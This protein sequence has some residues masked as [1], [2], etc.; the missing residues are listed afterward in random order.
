MAQSLSRNTGIWCRA[1]TQQ[2]SNWR[3]LISKSI[4]GLIMTAIYTLMICTASI[5]GTITVNTATTLGESSQQND[6]EQI[7][8]Y[9]RNAGRSDAT[10]GI[11]DT[12]VSYVQQ[13]SLNGIQGYNVDSTNSGNTVNSSGVFIPGQLLTN[14]LQDARHYGYIPY[15][16]VGGDR[17]S[18]L[19]PNPWTWSTTTWNQYR[20]YVYKFVH[21]VAI[22]F[23]FRGS[24]GFP[25]SVFNITSEPDINPVVW[26][27][28]N[29]GKN[30][31]IE[32]YNHLK[33]IYEIWQAAV[34]QVARENPSRQILV[35]GPNITSF[36]MTV[37]ATYAPFNWRDAFID[38]VANN[39]WRL[40]AFAYHSYGD[41]EAVGNS[42]P[43]P[44][45]GYLK[46]RIQAIRDKLN[47]R[48]LHSKIVQTEWGASSLADNSSLGRINYSH[49]GAAWMI[50]FFRDAVSKAL[51]SGT[52]LVLR[53]DSGNETIGNLL[54]PSFIHLRDGVQYPKP[55][56]NVCKML[57]LLPGERRGVQV[58]PSQP[59][60]VAIASGA[61]SAYGI[62]VANYRYLFDY[63]NRNFTDLS[64]PETVTIQFQN[65]PFSG[66]AV[67]QQYLIDANT[68]NLAKY[69]DA[70]QPPS[71][72]GSQLQQVADM[73]VNVT[74]G[75]A[76]LP[77]VTLGPSAVS[78]WIINKQ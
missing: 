57:S 71:Q 14:F 52:L 39:G 46:D 26:T 45:F 49:E 74:N 17:P 78:Q 5:A 50:A 11:T 70:G 42:P 20:D 67:V 37:N 23:Q 33:T 44:D 12:T 64:V 3:V 28:Q 56:Y 75:I 1:W 24:S 68:S 22:D 18:Y 35:Q 48:G 7:L 25:T 9:C 53:D 59:N 6:L 77:Q 38:D 10:I 32:R 2:T 63:P 54:S 13:L 30:G 51:D 61:G 29:P 47:S 62:I 72:T 4:I 41:F 8:T 36:G 21:Y 34:V 65:L 15:A 31:S 66:P 55:F 27:Q 76:V 69:L 73:K 16:S 43:H 40:D 60:L 19:P 58:D